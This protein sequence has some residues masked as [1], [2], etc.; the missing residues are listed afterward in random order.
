MSDRVYSGTDFAAMVS[1][2][3]TRLEEKGTARDERMERMEKQ[4]TTAVAKLDE[5]ADNVKAAK[6]GLRVGLWIAGGAGGIISW[7]AQHFWPFK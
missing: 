3:L 1:E 2:R 7:A 5:V 6:M 4:L